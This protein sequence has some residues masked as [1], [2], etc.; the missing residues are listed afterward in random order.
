MPRTSRETGLVFVV[1]NKKT[2]VFKSF[3]FQERFRKPPYLSINL[4]VFDWFSV[5]GRQK[6][7]DV[8]FFSN[9]NA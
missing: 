6:G 9:K 7:E 3:D 5:D 1:H 8:G 4:S 2:S